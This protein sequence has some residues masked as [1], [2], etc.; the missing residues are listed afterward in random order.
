V[1]IIIVAPVLGLD[2][3]YGNVR[4][5]KIPE[6]VGKKSGNLYAKLRGTLMT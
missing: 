6:K 5:G 4:F 1:L 2:R 3:S